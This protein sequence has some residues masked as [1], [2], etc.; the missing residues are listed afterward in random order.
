MK[1]MHSSRIVVQALPAPGT[2][3]YWD[4]KKSKGGTKLRKLNSKTAFSRGHCNNDVD[5]VIP[6]Q[7]KRIRNKQN[8]RMNAVCFGINNI[9]HV[10]A[11]PA[12]TMSPEKSP[13]IWSSDN[14]KSS[15]QVRSCIAD[16][17]AWKVKKKRSILNRKFNSLENDVIAC[18]LDN[19]SSVPGKNHLD[20]GDLVMH[21]SETGTCLPK[22]ACDGVEETSRKNPSK[23]SG[24]DHD[25]ETCGDRCSDISKDHIFVTSESKSI[26]EVENWNE[27]VPKVDNSMTTESCDFFNNAAIEMRGLQIYP[28]LEVLITYSRKRRKNSSASA[29]SLPSI[30]TDATSSFPITENKTTTTSPDH[31]Q[32]SISYSNNFPKEVIAGGG[33]LLMGVQPMFL[34]KSAGDNSC[35]ET[36]NKKEMIQID[37]Q[38][39]NINSSMASIEDGSP[40]DSKAEN[41]EQE[42]RNDTD[43]AVNVSYDC[44]LSKDSSHNAVPCDHGVSN[45]TYSIVST[46]EPLNGEIQ[47]ATE[48]SPSQSRDR[49]FVGE[50]SR[51]TNVGMILPLGRALNARSSKKLLV[52]DVNGLLADIVP[53]R[54]VPYSLEANIIVSGKAGGFSKGLFMTIF[55]NSALRDSMRNMELVLDFLLGDAKHKL[56]FCW[57]QSHC[58]DTGFPVVGTRRSKP[59]ILKKLKKLWDKYEPDLPWERGE[60]DES[61]TLLLD[62]SPHKAL[63]NPPNTAIFPNSY[64]Y[65]DE[66]DD[67]LGPGGDLRVYLERL[68]MAEN[69]QKYV[70]NNPYG[71]RPITDKNASWRY[72]RK[73]IA[74]ATYSQESGANKYSTHKCRY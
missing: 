9:D 13:H 5:D 14:I 67:S 51:I 72:Y 17:S 46:N 66:K 34:E 62:D 10:V 61:N 74:A 73:V 57:D 40:I 32:V 35:S 12:R 18:E 44:E 25:I 28:R 27:P 24:T 8:R 60:Y 58:T 50:R 2:P 36:W 19:A 68:S 53:L 11:A 4:T 7:S 55:C 69:V 39:E 31:C 64:H 45:D 38:K 3:D 71:Q 37:N 6:Q 30:M 21:S 43:A 23:S 20:K 65:L 47:S 49:G 15:T 26:S 1:T 59:I 63:C 48:D 70:E 52:L 33:T 56:L 54:Y 41:H 22:N 29:S 42:K 16:L